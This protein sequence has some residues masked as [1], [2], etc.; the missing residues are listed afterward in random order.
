MCQNWLLM[1]ENE[2]KCLCIF[3]DKRVAGV[4][5]RKGGVVPRI[6]TF[7]PVRLMAGAIFFRPSQRRLS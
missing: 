6:N 2:I 5:A 3:K 1:D 4:S 7:V